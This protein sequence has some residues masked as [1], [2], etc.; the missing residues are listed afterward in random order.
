MPKNQKQAVRKRIIEVLAAHFSVDEKIMVYGRLAVED[1]ADKIMQ[2]VA[3][4]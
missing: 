3:D 1:L 4:E 2:I